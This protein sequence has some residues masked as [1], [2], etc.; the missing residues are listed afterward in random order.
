MNKNIN[1]REAS[2]CMAHLWKN[3]LENK[4]GKNS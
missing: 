4:A 3:I 1:S 2:K